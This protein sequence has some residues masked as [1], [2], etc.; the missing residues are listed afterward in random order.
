M[1][2]WEIASFPSHSILTLR[3]LPYPGLFTLLQINLGSVPFVYRVELPR[4]EMM[5][6]E[7]EIENTDV[8]PRLDF[9]Q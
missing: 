8:C 2:F 7:I 3:I 4:V 5:N 1:S 9:E 6:E